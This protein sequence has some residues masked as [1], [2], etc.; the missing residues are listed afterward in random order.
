MLRSMRNSA[1][2]IKYLE[3]FITPN[4]R[5]NATRDIRVLKMG[6]SGLTAYYHSFTRIVSD[7]GANSMSQESLVL[8]FIAGL[9]PN[10]VRNTNLNLHMHNF[11]ASNPTAT[12]TNLYA[13]AHK[14]ISLTTNSG[15][16]GT[17]GKRAGPDRGEPRPQQWDRGHTQRPSPKQRQHP[18]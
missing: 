3:S 4:I 15:G 8:Y 11:L 16:I 1:N 2:V 18:Q 13:E 5:I 7:L 17:L 6:N 9:N 14:V 10:G 12:I